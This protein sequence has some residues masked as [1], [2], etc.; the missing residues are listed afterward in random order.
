MG[1][2]DPVRLSLEKG[3]A[4]AT[5]VVGIAL[6]GVNCEGK[7]TKGRRVCQNRLRGDGRLD[8]DKSR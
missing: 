1:L 8:G 5:L 3:R 6:G 7:V 4:H 2:F